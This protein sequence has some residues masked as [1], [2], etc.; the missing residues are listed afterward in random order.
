M[1]MLQVIPWVFVFLVHHRVD[2]FSV[3]MGRAMTFQVASNRRKL[4]AYRRY[5]ESD[6]NNVSG[7][8]NQIT[9]NTQHFSGT[10]TMPLPHLPTENHT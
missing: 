1:T 8:G 4:L 9:P 10:A 6:G 2:M 5:C 7:D 3:D